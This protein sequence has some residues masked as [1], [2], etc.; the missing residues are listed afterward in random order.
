VS[1][2][3][4]PNLPGRWAEDARIL[5]Q[6]FERDD[7]PTFGR[8]DWERFKLLRYI[9]NKAG[10]CEA[11]TAW[12]VVWPPSVRHEQRPDL[13]RDPARLN[14]PHLS[15]SHPFKTREYDWLTGR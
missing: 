1:L 14:S 2:K 10:V 12:P 9:R 8:L 15:R 4:A 7:L 11:W 13:L 5:R 6:D 3:A